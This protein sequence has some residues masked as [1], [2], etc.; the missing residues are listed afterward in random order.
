MLKLRILEGLGLIFL[1]GKLG[2]ERLYLLVQLFRLKLSFCLQGVELVCQLLDLQIVTHFLL[3]KFDH[4]VAELLLES[5]HESIQHHI[6]CTLDLQRALQLVIL[7]L[8]LGQRL[9][10][11][12]QLL[13]TIAYCRLKLAK[14]LFFL[15]NE[16]LLLSRLEFLLVYFGLQG[17]DLGLTFLDYLI[18]FLEVFSLLLKLLLIRNQ[19]L[20]RRSC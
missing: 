19:M 7:A 17:S 9:L 2:L 12:L 8:H 6:S 20:L 5:T 1:V 10:T 4:L 14:L 16:L 11:R 13:L 18:S 15:G 3:L